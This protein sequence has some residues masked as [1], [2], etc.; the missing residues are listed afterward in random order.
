MAVSAS[1]L[2]LLSSS[3]GFFLVRAR[4]WSLSA[5]LRRPLSS[6]R[7]S[8][9][10]DDNSDKA[11]A[12]GW[13]HKLPDES[14]SFWQ[15]SSRQTNGL[16]RRQ[17]QSS[18]SDKEPRTGWLHNTEAPKKEKEGTQ[19]TDSDGSA[20]SPARR[21]LEQATRMK[22]LNH[23]MVA[24]PAFHACGDARQ[25]VVTEHF[26]SVP[27]YRDREET[28]RL[29]VY[30]SIVECVQDDDWQWWQTLA[31]KRPDQRAQMY[32]E[33]AGMETAKDMILYLQGGPG[34]G[35]PTPIVG[36]SATKAGSWAGKALAHY[37][38]VV[39]MDQRGTGR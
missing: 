14:S 27:T 1:V 30:F 11:P 8:S 9:S 39:L 34:F 32:V 22:E 37:K 18:K 23:R 5:P 20:V 26:L 15:N 33:H 10:G 29:D 38:R 6:I 28:P 19:D 7:A 24:P 12:T 21:L 3:G 2:I 25:V 31:E 13:D 35:A 16:G 36:L 4:A 17:Q